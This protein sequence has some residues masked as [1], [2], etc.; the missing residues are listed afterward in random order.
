MNFVIYMNSRPKFKCLDFCGSLNI[1]ERV[2]DIV[3]IMA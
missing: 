2:T 1:A 3:M